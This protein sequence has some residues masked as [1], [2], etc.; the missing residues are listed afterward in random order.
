MR[1]KRLQRVLE[2]MPHCTSFNSRFE[3]LCADTHHLRA[4]VEWVLLWEFHTSLWPILIGRC[5]SKAALLPQGSGGPCVC[6]Q[7]ERTG[8]G[9]ATS[10][11][12]L[13]RSLDRKTRGASMDNVNDCHIGGA[14]PERSCTNRRRAP[15]DGG[16][17]RRRTFKREGGRQQVTR[18]LTE[19][20]VARF[21]CNDTA[22]YCDRSGHC[23]GFSAATYTALVQCRD[24]NINQYIR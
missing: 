15:R 3:Q 4:P 19:V 18:G 9:F 10:D 6:D 12:C 24:C 22:A 21:S 16:L 8:D 1:E 5:Y 2:R 20:L 17:S 7:G 23:S 11:A 13:I 14:R